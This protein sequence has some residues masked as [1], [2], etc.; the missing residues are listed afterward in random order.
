VSVWEGGAERKRE[1]GKGDLVDAEGFRMEAAR[2]RKKARITQSR[3]T[4]SRIRSKHT[5]CFM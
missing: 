1:G 2:L 4:R 5:I 3:I